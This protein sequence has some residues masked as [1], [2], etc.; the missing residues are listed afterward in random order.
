MRIAGA[1]AGC[2]LCILSFGTGGCGYSDFRLPE[3]A[4]AEPQ[5][6]YEWEPRGAPVLPHGSPGDGDSHDALNP[7]VVRRGAAYYNFYSG[8]DGRTWRTLLAT[9]ADGL[10]WTKDGAVLN[11]EPS[12]GE[13]DYIA[14]NGSAL[15]DEGEFWYWYQAGPKDTPRIGRQH[16]ALFLPGGSVGRGREQGTPSLAI[17]P[18]IEIVV[19]G[20]PANH[21]GVQGVMRVR[22]AVAAM[23][24]D[25]SGARIPF[26]THGRLGAGQFG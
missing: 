25:G 3:L 23:R 4:P 15:F 12:A 1:F 10:A 16:H 20:S 18:R 5:L 19:I 9:S 8:F 11:P 2:A 21:G 24:K 22:I 6:R 13:G 14:A 7:S 26:V 17:E